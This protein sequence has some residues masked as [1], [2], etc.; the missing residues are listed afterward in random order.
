MIVGKPTASG[1]APFQLHAE[2]VGAGNAGPIPAQ[3]RLLSR[4]V[5]DANGMEKLLVDVDTTGLG[6]GSYEIRFTLQP[7][8][9]TASVRSETAFQIS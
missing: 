9:D 8:G 6:T 5:P 4:T 7:E 2:F 3:V 1:L